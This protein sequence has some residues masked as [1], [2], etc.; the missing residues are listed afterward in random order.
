MTE[1]EQNFAKE[2]IE[3]YG[4][5]RFYHAAIWNSSH[6]IARKF[7]LDLNPTANWNVREKELGLNF[8]AGSI[9]RVNFN[10]NFHEELC[11]VVFAICKRHKEFGLKN[12]RPPNNIHA[13]MIFSEKNKWT[14]SYFELME[15]I[16]ERRENN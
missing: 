15:E 16:D 2:I 1:S 8:V 14:V 10:F 3:F 6:E 4:E 9:G 5:D 12:K 7:F 11:R 13:R